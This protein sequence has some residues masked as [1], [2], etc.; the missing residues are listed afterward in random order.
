VEK[1]LREYFSDMLYKVGL[2][3]GSYAIFVAHDGAGRTIIGIHYL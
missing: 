2:A 1:D 3:G